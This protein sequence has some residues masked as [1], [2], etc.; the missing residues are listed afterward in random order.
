MSYSA[1]N[2]HSINMQKSAII[3]SPNT[4][5]DLKNQIAKKMQIDKIDVYDWFLGLP[6]KFP[7]SK[8]Q[9]MNYIAERIEGKMS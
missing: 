1:V 6:S 4:P 8:Q 7:R 5:L 2:G 3:F 9:A